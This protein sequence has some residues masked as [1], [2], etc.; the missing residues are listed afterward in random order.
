MTMR[1]DLDLLHA[2][3]TVAETGSLSAAA[4]RLHRSQSAVSE[5]IRKL[6]EMVGV[7]L[8]LRGKTGATPTPAGERLLGH[9]RSLLEQSDAVVRDVKGDHIEGELRLG[10]TE[11]FRPSAVTSILKRIRRT[12][13]K[14][15]LHVSIEKSIGIGDALHR[16]EF[17][18][19]IPMRIAGARAAAKSSSIELAREPLHWLAA[20]DAFDFDTPGPLPLILLPEDCSL[21]RLVLRELR[22]RKVD[23]YVAHT[24]SGIA[25]A[26][27]ALLAGLGITCLNDS[28]MPAGVRIVKPGRRLP[29]LPGVE[30]S[31]LSGRS[32][33][34]NLLVSRVKSILVEQ[35]AQAG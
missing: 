9:A 26:Q 32:S 15:R 33:A 27:Q 31:L 14:L 16:D 7:Q 28:A 21:H 10:I 35:F 24:A 22:R 30:F 12:Y 18:V 11:Y 17:D 6:E 34:G 25:G 29:R 23:F 3:V 4:P 1:L 13:P 20:S 19:G 2:L 8:L 5:Q